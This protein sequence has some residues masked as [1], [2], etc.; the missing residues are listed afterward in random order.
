[1]LALC[2]LSPAALSGGLLARY[3]PPLFGAHLR[4]PSRRFHLAHGGEVVLRQRWQEDGAKTGSAVWDASV[5]L[6][7]YLDQVH[8]RWPHT[9]HTHTLPRPDRP[10]YPRPL[11][12]TPTPTL[13]S[14][15]SIRNTRDG[16]TYTC[17][18]SARGSG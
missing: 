17:L 6:A 11:P 9:L 16:A 13:P 15:T 14:P 8:T 7:H 12:Y 3:E 10:P 18:S 1:M 2:A 5:V 4:A